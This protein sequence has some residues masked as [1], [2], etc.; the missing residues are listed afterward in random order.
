MLLLIT[1]RSPLRMLFPISISSQEY[2]LKGKHCDIV[3]TIA[4]MMENNVLKIVIPK[5]KNKEE[6]EDDLTVHHV[7]VE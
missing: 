3:N 2:T 6:D 5:L 1:S 7:D 4:K